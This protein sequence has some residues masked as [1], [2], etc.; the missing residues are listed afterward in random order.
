MLRG[1]CAEV[2]MCAQQPDRLGILGQNGIPLNTYNIVFLRAAPRF[3][4]A[5]DLTGDGRTA[6]RG[7]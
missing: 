1:L 3:G 2:G 4:F 7:G 6:I 5:Y